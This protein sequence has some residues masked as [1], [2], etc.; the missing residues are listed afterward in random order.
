MRQIKFWQTKLLGFTPTF[1]GF[2]ARTNFQDGRHF[3]FERVLQSFN[4]FNRFTRK[5]NDYSYVIN[6]LY[7]YFHTMQFLHVTNASD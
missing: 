1:L 6:V 2:F 7:E 3:M 4:Q 5:N